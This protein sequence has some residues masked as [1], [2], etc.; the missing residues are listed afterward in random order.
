MGGH[1]CAQRT[2]KLAMMERLTNSKLVPEKRMNRRRSHFFSD[3]KGQL[4]KLHL[5]DCSSD[6]N[7]KIKNVRTVMNLPE[8]EYIVRPSYVS[9]VGTKTLA[10]RMPRG[11]IDLY[12]AM[13]RPMSWNVLRK[14]LEHLARGV[15]WLH[16]HG[17]AHRDI[18][19][20]NVVL[21]GGVFKWIDFDYSSSLTDW[22][23]CGSRNFTVPISISHQWCC[24]NEKRS[25]RM[26]VY[27][28]G[29]LILVTLWRASRQGH[30]GYENYL[31]TMFLCQTVTNFAHRLEGEA[32]LWTTCALRCCQFVPP[33][34][35]PLPTTKPYAI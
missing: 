31:H 8:S 5:E 16:E 3:G 1:L 22:V 9:R 4:W 27:A 7:L 2:S 33:E 30:F 32:G 34:K 11:H 35:I 28:F 24:S 10:I 12:E 19:P 18:K 14:G 25:R 17:V 29:K 20:E 23:Y 6:V 15:H 26:D 21:D 13:K